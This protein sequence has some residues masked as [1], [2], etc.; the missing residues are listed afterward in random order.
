[1]A[2]IINYTRPPV[3][4]SP[5]F[6]QTGRLSHY[7]SRTICILSPKR[8]EFYTIMTLT[9]MSQVDSY[10]LGHHRAV[11]FWNEVIVT[12]RPDMIPAVDV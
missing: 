5:C 8:T 10:V 4:G 9:V 2:V 6:F 11:G 1:M 7:S 12:F 3:H